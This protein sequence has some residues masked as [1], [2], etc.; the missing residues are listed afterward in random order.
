MDQNSKDPWK[1]GTLH[2]DPR[3]IQPTDAVLMRLK[4]QGVSMKDFAEILG[5]SYSTLS[6]W[7][8]GRTEPDVHFLLQTLIH[9]DNRDAKSYALAALTMVAPELFRP[10]SMFVE[11]FIEAVNIVFPKPDPDDMET[12]RFI[13]PEGTFVMPG[14]DFM[15]ADGDTDKNN[16]SHK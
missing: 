16:S 2:D 7:K 9:N 14:R 3:T 13:R 15:V 10:P 5:V 12:V 6:N 8:N 11:K 4:Y 1:P